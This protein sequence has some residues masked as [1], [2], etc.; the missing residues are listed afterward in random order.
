MPIMHF[1]QK[2]LILIFVTAGL[3]VQISPALARP[4]LE[5]PVYNEETQ[6]YLEMI[7]YRP[8][9][10]GYG[11][12]W[13]KAIEVAESRSL[14][15]V[16]GRLAVIKSPQVD[17]FIRLNLRPPGATW[18]GLFY[19]CETRKLEWVTG[20]PLKPTDYGNFDVQNWY[21]GYN[22]HLCKHYM[23]FTRYPAYLD[24]KRDKRWAITTPEKLY[25][26]FII[27]YPT[28]SRIEGD[29]IESIPAPRAPSSND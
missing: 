2:H 12:T 13:K 18:F 9:T 8:T 20:E 14:G 17:M 1:L 26:Y 22:H 23:G 21:R 24:M 6:S 19:N 5:T 15:G 11:L 10:G 4:L 3:G 28:G 25:Y 29:N 27:E 7:D 16:R